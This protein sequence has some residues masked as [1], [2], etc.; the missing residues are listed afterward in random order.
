[1]LIGFWRQWYKNGKIFSSGVY[2]DSKQEGDWVYFS[3][4]NTDSSK[5]TFKDGKPFDGAKIEWYANGKKETEIKYVNGQISGPVSYWYDNGAKKRVENYLNNVLNGSVIKWKRTGEK[6][7][8]QIYD[9]GTLKEQ[10]E[11]KY[12]ATGQIDSTI[13]FHY[14]NKNNIINKIV[15]KWSPNGKL[16]SKLN[17][18]NIWKGKII[19]WW[20]E[21]AG[22]RKSS[23]SYDDGKKNGE[24]KSWYKNKNLKSEGFYRND[25]MNGDW[26]FY[27]A[28]GN[29][30]ADGSFLNGNG[31]KK[32]NT[33]KIPINGRTG[34]WTGWHENGVKW[35]ELS[36][37][38]GKKHGVQKNWYDNGQKE[39]QGE[40]EYGKPVRTWFWWYFD[41]APM[42]EGKYNLEGKFEGLYFINPQVPTF[43][44][45]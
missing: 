29:I 4:N 23:V 5:I 40:Y 31:K 17:N 19:D 16:I 3:P 43:I 36:F 8:K 7:L 20:D 42:Q 18:G 44:T 35:S 14:N 37:K 10:K 11:Y 45:P 1:M 12:Y 24:Y 15:T 30:M 21:N 33:T 28:N 22:I 9:Q 41:G 34:N 27:Y 13:E 26:K 6:K 25:L 32:N 38:N 2:Q 39:L